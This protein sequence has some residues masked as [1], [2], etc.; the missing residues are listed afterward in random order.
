MAMF[1]ALQR[2]YGTTSVQLKRLEAVSRSPIYAHFTETL[3]GMPTVR[4]YLAQSRLS[5]LNMTK[6]D[7]NQNIYFLNMTSNR[8]LSVRLEFLGGLLILAV[9]SNCVMLRRTISPSDVGLSLSYALQITTQL[10]MMVRFVTMT[11]SDFNSVER[12]QEY[13]AIEPE[14]DPLGPSQPPK[15][16][17][18]EG[19]VSSIHA[20][21]HLFLS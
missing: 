10:N 8:W 4:A 20:S 2:Y 1:I 6:L 18:T 17:P 9:A 11:E 15:N 14:A 16:W 7:A 5:K 21:C 19:K 13:T 12:V 3:S